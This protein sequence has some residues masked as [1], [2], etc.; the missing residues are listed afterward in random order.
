MD[1]C[2]LPKGKEGQLPNTATWQLRYHLQS[3]IIHGAILQHH[4]VKDE[5]TS[6][7]SLKLLL[8]VLH[9]ILTVW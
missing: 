5:N 9:G 2:F 7:L 8:S 1:A 3:L 4:V 6:C